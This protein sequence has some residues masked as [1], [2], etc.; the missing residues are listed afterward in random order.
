MQARFDGQVGAFAYLLF[1]LLYFPCVAT[2]GVIRRET[3]TAWAAFVATWTTGV[4][5]FTATVYY[6][7]ATYAAHP[8]SSLTWI[9][10]LTLLL[11]V[12]VTGLRFWAQ[13]GGRGADSLDR[14]ER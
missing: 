3:G 1:I 10:G 13:R 4:A 5:Y 12:T 11:A 9:I 7:A 8:Q 2:M 6:Q 14:A